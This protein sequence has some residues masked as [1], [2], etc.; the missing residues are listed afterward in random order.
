[1]YY[2][3]RDGTVRDISALDPGSGDFGESGW[4]GLTV[5]HLI[6]QARPAQHPTQSLAQ[7]RH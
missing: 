7:S 5:D 1:M 6:S 3:T 4:G 2:F